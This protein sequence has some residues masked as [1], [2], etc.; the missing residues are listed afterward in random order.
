MIHGVSRV[1]QAPSAERSGAWGDFFF[2]GHRWA[3]LWGSPI[4]GWMVYNG[5]ENNVDGFRATG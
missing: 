5:S 3:R 2:E 4:N 1:F